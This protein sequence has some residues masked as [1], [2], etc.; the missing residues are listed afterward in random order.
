M[1]P[2][3]FFQRESLAEIARPLQLQPYIPTLELEGLLTGIDNLRHDVYLS[4]KFCEITRDYIRRLIARDGKVEDLLKEPEKL[5]FDAPPQIFRPTPKEETKPIEA[6]L[7]FKR[8]LTQLLGEGLNRAKN[9]NKPA[10]DV[11]L[12]LAVVKLL[13]AELLAQYNGILERL[14]ARQAEQE[15]PRTHT[16]TM[17]LTKAVQARER[18]AAFQLSKK[19]LL[20]KSGQELF[21]TLRDIEKESLTRMRRALFGA[22]EG[23][24]Y[25]ILLNRLMFTDDGRDDLILAEHYVMLG[26]FERDPDRFANVEEIARQFL[27]SLSQP[28]K[29]PEEQVELDPLLNSPDNAQELL[30]GG[31][32]D[33]ST[34][35]GKA[36]KALL[37]AWMDVLETSGV[38]DRVVAA[39]ETAPLLAEYA[40]TINPQQLKAA[41]VSKVERARVEQLLHEHSSLSPATFEAAV[42]R[43]SK[44]GAAEKTKVAVRFL[45]DYLIYHRDLRSFELLVLSLDRVNLLV[46]DRLRELSAINSTLY[47]FLLPTE[48]KQHEEKVTH[49]VI[50]KADVRDSTTLTR[51]L[52]GRGLNPASYFS[53]NFYDPINKLLPKYDAMKVFIEGDAVILALFGYEGKQTFPVARTCVLAR[54]MAQ[55]VRGYNERS[56]KDGLPTLEIGVGISFQDSAPL[57]LMDGNNR[58]MIS[59]ALNESDRLSG[60]NKGARLF[61]KPGEN[62]FNVYTFKTVEDEDT[63]GNPDEF[64]MRYNIGG[65][66]LSEAS[67]QALQQEITLEQH[68]AVLPTI[69]GEQTIRLFSGLVPLGNGIFHVL[70][71]REAHIARIDG[72]NF[73][74]KSWTDRRY[75]EICTNQKIYEFIE[76]QAARPKAAASAS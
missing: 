30:A 28:M 75:Y 3:P 37:A 34:P 73:T 29:S 26:N 24:S 27:A 55:I 59:K 54:E 4:P 39:Y 76:A 51:T 13:R 47:E 62:L 44:Y 46:N 69:W 74:F 15:G 71:I 35:K 58:I 16:S 9:E 8:A 18:I 50:M 36:Q 11:L 57:Y 1:A 61:V 5:A 56:L 53:L 40:P 32:P 41:L 72:S 25:S 38:L 52:I 68:E 7:D 21:Q 60:C 49:H 2:F 31:T 22:A 66:H 14:R 63:G 17:Q 64:L 12:R 42:R 67:F 33:E 20:R 10:L 45:R 65:I 48:Q 70:A 19:V 6:P 23:A 43:I